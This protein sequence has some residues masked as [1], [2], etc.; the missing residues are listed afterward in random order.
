[1]PTLSELLGHAP[2]VN[3][4]VR[5]ENDWWIIRKQDKGKWVIVRR[6]KGSTLDVAETVKRYSQKF[7]GV[8]FRTEWTDKL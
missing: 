8:I 3:L 2:V 6:C 7:D 1:M 5:K 4:R